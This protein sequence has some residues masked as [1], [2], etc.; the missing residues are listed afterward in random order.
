[1]TPV[2]EAPVLQNPPPQ[3]A[4]RRQPPTHTIELKPGAPASNA[5]RPSPA[6]QPQ[7]NPSA[8]PLAPSD[9]APPVVIMQQR[10]E[11]LPD[12]IKINITVS[13]KFVKLEYNGQEFNSPS[14]INQTSLLE[15]ESEGK[16]REYGEALFKAIINDE[17]TQIGGQG[18]TTF[19]GYSAAINDDDARGKARIS[20]T[21]DQAALEGTEGADLFEICWEYLKD[22]LS[23][24]PLSVSEKAPFYR[25]QGKRKSPGA[26]DA[27][28]LKILVAICNPVTLEQKGSEVE[29]LVSLTIE[30]E[31]DII[32][33]AL[34]RLKDAKLADYDIWSSA[35]GDKPVTLFNL[36]ERLEDGFHVLHLISHGAAVD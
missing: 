6:T 17:D 36:Q 10:Y 32:E 30:Q 22:P 34:K 14:R 19:R 15:L 21:L 18:K 25:L 26:V 16:L 24:V 3:I 12:E 20:V 11:P 8:Q 31:R 4:Q 27:L 35:N 28:P 33:R 13:S 7:F 2:V 29:K 23:D 9:L 5:P 1:M